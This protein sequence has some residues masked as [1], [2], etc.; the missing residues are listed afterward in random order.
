MMNREAKRGKEENSCAHLDMERI[1]VLV[2]GVLDFPAQNFKCIEFLLGQYC[3]STI[4][5]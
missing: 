5:S 4:L 3:R 1:S 2:F